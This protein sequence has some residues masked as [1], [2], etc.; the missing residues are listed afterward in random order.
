MTKKSVALVFSL[1]VLT[2]LVI[3]FVISRS[4]PESSK[5]L[6]GNANS[7]ITLTDMEE[8]NLLSVAVKRVDG[9]FVLELDEDGNWV[10][11]GAPFSLNPDEV[12]RVTRTLASIKSGE[13]VSEELGESRLSEFGLDRPEARIFVADKDGNS[14][15]VEVGNVSPL[16]K[17]RYARREGS[18][19]LVFLPSAVTEIAFMNG[20]D[21]R[22]RSLPAPNLDEIERLEFRR[23]G[24]VFQMVP[25][26][27]PDPYVNSAGDYVITKP[28]QGKYYLDEGSF[29]IRI[30]EEAPLP[31]TVVA[32]LDNENPGD[33]EFEL[34]DE[35]ADMLYLSDRDGT[36][37][38]LILGASDGEG[39]R[40]AR[41]GDGDESLFKLRESELGFLD[42]EPFSLVSKLVFLASIERVAR[43]KIE[44]GEDAWTLTRIGRNESE[45]VKD[46]L[47]LI[48]NMEITFEEFS[49]LFQNLMGIS[50]EGQVQQKRIRLEPEITISVTNSKPDVDPLLIRYWNYDEV[51]Y[52]V[53]MDAGQPEFLVGRYQIQRLINRLMALP[54]V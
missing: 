15:V 3:V 47:F 32:Y 12:K 49:S 30:R 33:A 13:I 45:E 48:D 50:R 51:Y 41:M 46:D 23:N 24:K 6:D 11:S 5:E 44:A 35:K 17:R 1:G 2:A 29:R 53:G 14:E 39:N 7:S 22:D 38:H 31:T 36:V 20:D 16:G 10:L 8:Q 27:E 34:T 43:V 54:R 40:Y 25:S 4:L 42:T 18:H 9:G 26:T 28:W 19:N 37:L 21:F 52:Q